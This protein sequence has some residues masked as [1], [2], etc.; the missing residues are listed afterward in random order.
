MSTPHVVDDELVEAL[1]EEF[2]KAHEDGDGRPRQY[3]GP[4]DHHKRAAR[5]FIAQHRLVR[6]P[7]EADGW[8][9]EIRHEVHGVGWLHE[10]DEECARR[11]ATDISGSTGRIRPVY[12]IPGQPIEVTKEGGEG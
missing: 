11:T 4:C 5:D 3:T 8:Q 6:L 1:A 10:P 2:C 12:R 9:S 7:E